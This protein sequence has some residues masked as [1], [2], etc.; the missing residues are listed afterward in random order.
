MG[1]S[2]SMGGGDVDEAR[3]RAKRIS[4]W[5][6]FTRRGRTPSMKRGRLNS[7]YLR[8]TLNWMK[9]HSTADCVYSYV[10]NETIWRHMLKDIKGT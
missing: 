8:I 7:I 1:H 6:A 4:A 9:S 2:K 3:R 10:L 5:R